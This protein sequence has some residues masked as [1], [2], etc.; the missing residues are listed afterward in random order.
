MGD[1]KLPQEGSCV[2]L[3]LDEEEVSSCPFP[4][5]TQE[6]SWLSEPFGCLGHRRS[7]D[8][9]LR[10]FAESSS[11]SCGRRPFQGAE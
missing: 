4:F 1:G 5:G 3:C 7:F 10:L 8:D 11:S 2:G 6:G 9:L